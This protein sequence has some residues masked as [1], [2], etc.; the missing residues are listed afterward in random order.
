MPSSEK[1]TV[2]PKFGKEVLVLP[3]SDYENGV[4]VRKIPVAGVVKGSKFNP[5]N[6][7]DGHY[8]EFIG[9]LAGESNEA[10]FGFK[11]SA[12][13]VHAIQNF[14]ETKA[15]HLMDHFR[16]FRFDPECM[17]QGNCCKIR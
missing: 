17:K 8:F 15:K 13:N 3:H 2:K 5:D 9:P 6:V 16:P 14:S 11:D 1:P 10:R 12:E 7:L 4:L